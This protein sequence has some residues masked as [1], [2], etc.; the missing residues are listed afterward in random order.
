MRRTPLMSG[1]A[2]AALLATVVTVPTAATAAPTG[3]ADPFTRAVAQ[4]KAHSG[5]GLAAD[6]QTFTPRTVVTDA[7]GTEHVRL[8]RYYDGLPVL[9]G[10]LVVHLGKGNS[11]RGATHRLADA[12]Q[13]AREGQLSSRRRQDRLRRVDRHRPFGR[14]RAARLRRRRHRDHPRLRGGRRRHARRPHPQR[15]ARAGRRHHRRGPR[16]VGGCAAE[17]TGKPTTPARRG[18]HNALRQHLPAQRPGPGRPQDLRPQRR[19]QRHRH[20]VHR[21]RQRLRQRHHSTNR[22]T[23]AVDAHYGAARP[24]TTTRTCTAATAS[25]TTAS[26]RYSRV[27]YGSNYVNAFWDDTCSH[28]LRR[29]R[30][31]RLRPADLARRGRPRDDPRR[32]QHTAGLPTPVSPAASTRRPPTSSARWWSSTRPTPTTR[33]TT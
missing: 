14:R 33:A 24:G 7:D 29:R 28:D 21:R 13:R 16:L 31:H 20:P 26:A 6:G 19:D 1:L 15:A 11:W 5:A 22:Q 10:D 25:A 27:H 12:P 23:A 9:G 2:T 8:N 32:H 18:R 17:G 30:R 3:S 4:L